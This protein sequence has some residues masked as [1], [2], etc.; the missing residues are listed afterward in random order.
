MN[1]I[2]LISSRR[3]GKPP[4]II[5]AP[6]IGIGLVM[7]LPLSYLI[8]RGMDAS[9][10]T[11]ELLLKPRP[12]VT[13]GRTALLMFTVTLTSVLISVPLAWLTT[14]TNL[15]LH[16]MWSVITVLPLV[17]PSFVGGYLFVSALGPRGLL[18]QA[19]S[20]LGVDRLPEIYGLA[21]ATLTLS[22]LSYPYVLLTIRGAVRNLDPA[23][24]ESSRALGYGT[25]QTFVRVSL[26]QLRPAITAGSLLVALYT[27]SDF[28]A[29]SL[30]RY[31]T[32]TWVIFQQ[33]ESS[34]DRSLIA[35][36]SLMVAI[37]AISTVLIDIYTRGK[38][39]YHS[40]GPG[41][42]RTPTKR[43]LGGW[44]WPALTL[45]TGIAMAS[46]IVPASILWYWLVRGVSAG[47]PLSIILHDTWNSISVSMLAAVTTSILS[48]PL[49]IMIVR[50]PGRLASLIERV[51]YIGFALP[52]IVVAVS[53]V[54]FAANYAQP[55]YQTM[56]L[57][58]F[59]YV[60]LFFPTALGATRASLLQISPRLEEAA[61]S[62]GYT[63]LKAVR[64]VTIPLAGPGVVMGGSIVFLITMKELPATMILGSLGFSTL[65]TSVWS[66]ASEAFFAQAALP[67]LVLIAVSSVPMA[68]LVAREK[69]D[70]S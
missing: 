1:L 49:A 34:L 63:S 2:S 20:P 55:I 65:A 11:W 21:G 36:V 59:A 24:E 50:Y 38:L 30:M 56:W 10:T 3:V 31:K 47:E 23:L 67:A 57:L 45:M 69:G 52:G 58:I 37:I 61:R 48:I 66:A 26:P 4:I 39:R 35:L 17:I 27:L 32:F 70:F 51:S 68:V 6:A 54:F 62:L 5:L 9:E 41:T 15:P 43:N 64:S 29:V 46:I 53:L 18:Q 13:L 33:Y 22:L 19:L 25:F 7:L 28:G 14:R 40:V 44:K 60:I 12:L 42:A 8:I 16:R